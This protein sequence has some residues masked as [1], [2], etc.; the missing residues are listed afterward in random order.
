ML[1]DTGFYTLI[2]IASCRA[3]IIVLLWEIL[4]YKKAGFGHGSSL[5]CLNAFLEKNLRFPKP[6]Q[7]FA[8]DDTCISSLPTDGTSGGTGGGR[9][10]QTVYRDR[11]QC[12]L[13]AISR[14]WMLD[15]SSYGL[16][17]YTLCTVFLS[18]LC[19]ILHISG[20]GWR[21][22][23]MAPSM[24]WDDACHSGFILGFPA[25]PTPGQLHQN[26]IDRHLA[27]RKSKHHECVIRNNAHE[28][29][30]QSSKLTFWW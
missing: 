26:A 11:G 9:N 1:I 19:R 3:C 30:R 15:P 23:S 6:A 4:R 25:T 5:K 29:S 27:N 7:H 16:A 13:S 2:S 28:L 12:E 14:Q 22:S 10:D 24:R 8:T 18:P 21:E 20:W 17:R